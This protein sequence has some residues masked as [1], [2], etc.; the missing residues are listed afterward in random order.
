M[1]IQ[2]M[3]ENDQQRSE[4]YRST[5]ISALDELYREARKRFDADDEFAERA[6]NRVVL[7][8]SGDDTTLRAW[9]EIVDQSKRYFNEVYE[10]LDVSLDDGDAVGRASTTA[11][12]ATWPATWS[13]GE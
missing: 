10:K 3:I 7:L 12:S 9:R 5:D 4:G 13:R 6:R 2:H 8:Q 1:L 11:C